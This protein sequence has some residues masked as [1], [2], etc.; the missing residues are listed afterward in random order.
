[1]LLV[2]QLKPLFPFPYVSLSLRLKLVTNLRKG[3]EWGKKL[4]GEKLRVDTEVR[5]T[6]LRGKY[7]LQQDSWG[8]LQGTLNQGGNHR[9]FSQLGPGMVKYNLG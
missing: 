4:G 8:A 2:E 3:T 5:I 9:Y 1:M 6:P 7:L